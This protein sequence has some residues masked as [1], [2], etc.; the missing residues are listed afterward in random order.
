MGKLWND[1]KKYR[2][3]IHFSFESNRTY[4]F[5]DVFLSLMLF[6][7]NPLQNILQKSFY[8]Y[9]GVGALLLQIYNRLKIS[10][11]TIK[12]VRT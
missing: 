12:F 4:I 5:Q 6:G 7:A 3:N 10:C 2:N 1:F 11:F 8:H 9:L